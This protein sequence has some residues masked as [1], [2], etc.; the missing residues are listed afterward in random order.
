MF[1]ASMRGQVWH[2]LIGGLPGLHLLVPADEVGHAQAQQRHVH[3][4]GGDVQPVW[5]VGLA[6]LGRFAVGSHIELYDRG[7]Y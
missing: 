4:T 7:L 6:N 1:I 3:H 2:L 5:H